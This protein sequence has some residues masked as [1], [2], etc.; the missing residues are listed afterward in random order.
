MKTLN[1][2][3][4]RFDRLLNCGPPGLWLVSSA[5]LALAAPS[6][7]IL[8]QNS[9]SN[10]ESKDYILVR[11]AKANVEQERALAEVAAAYGE[12]GEQLGVPSACDLRELC[13]DERIV[14]RITPAYVQ[15]LSEAPAQPT[16]KLASFPVSFIEA[17]GQD[18]FTPSAGG[19]MEA[20]YAKLRQSLVVLNRQ[21]NRTLLYRY[22][23]AQDTPFLPWP[24]RMPSTFEDVTANFHSLSTLGG[25]ARQIQH[26]IAPQGYDNLRY[27]S[28]PGGF[29]VA[30]ELERIGRS[31]PVSPEDRWTRGKRGGAGS[32]FDYW[33]DLMKGENDRFRVFVFIVTDSD[34]LHGE[35][36]A[37]E[38][39]LDYWRVRGRPAL[40]RERASAMAL[41]GTRV[42]LYTYEF[43][44]SRS[45]GARLVANS[46]DPLRAQ[47]NKHAL[48]L[49]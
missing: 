31:R 11:A 20:S 45:K 25:I 36:S 32:I 5:C 38:A 37:D 15:L 8:A 23:T 14:V 33:A 43:R 41:P 13:R 22:P 7:P 28:V 12:I 18:K 48:G 17:A 27:F 24:V 3:Q 49:P 46:H 26:K 10:P 39:D 29:A 19:N 16:V 34:V 2:C 9:G 6:S 21:A 30:T 44:A 35:Q 1:F 47:Q 42:W 4:R 40:S